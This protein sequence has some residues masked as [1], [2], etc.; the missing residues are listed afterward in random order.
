MSI[1]V[2]S[3]LSFKH[4]RNIPANIRW[5]Q[6]RQQAWAEGSVQHGTVLPFCRAGVPWP[7]RGPGQDAAFAITHCLGKHV[8]KLREGMSLSSGLHHFWSFLSSAFPSLPASSLWL[9]K[10][11]HV[12]RSL[13]GFSRHCFHFSLSLLI[14]PCSLISS[15]PSQSSVAHKEAAVKVQQQRLGCLLVPAVLELESPG[16]AYCVKTHRQCTSAANHDAVSGFCFSQ[17][18]PVPPLHQCCSFVSPFHVLCFA[19]ALP[20]FPLLPSPSPPLLYQMQHFSVTDWQGMQQLGQRRWS[21]GRK[22]RKSCS[23]QR[24]QQKHWKTSFLPEVN[25][26]HPLLGQQIKMWSLTQFSE[27]TLIAPC[28]P[29]VSFQ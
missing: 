28:T 11:I 1:N 23:Q 13:G 8:G 25:P 16:W 2:L 22:R 14:P 6:R 17:R 7:H 9:I 3:R 5:T 18:L 12:P 20:A 27:R 19:V 21:G 29:T 15:L 10:H 24:R 4:G 26:S